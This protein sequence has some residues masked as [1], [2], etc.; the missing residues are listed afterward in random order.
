MR[1]R[2]VRDELLSVAG[3]L[4]RD[5]ETQLNSLRKTRG[6]SGSMTHSDYATIPQRKK[7][8]ITHDRYRTS[9]ELASSY[10]SSH[11]T[12]YKWAGTTNFPFLCQTVS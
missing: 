9:Q 5:G 7:T 8:E 2:R 1:P 11:G 6:G 12:S 3:R 4:A 10:V